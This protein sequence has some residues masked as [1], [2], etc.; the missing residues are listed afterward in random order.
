MAAL[1]EV[2]QLDKLYGGLKAV[3][4]VSFEM[5]E[6]S[7][8]GLIGPNGAGKTTLFNVVSGVEPATSGRVRFR[9]EDVTNW[10]AHRIAK[11]GLSRTF[12]TV[13]LFPQISV[14]DNAMV[15]AFLHT[16]DMETARENAAEKLELVGLYEQRDLPL[17]SLTLVDRKRV[18]MARALC[19]NPELLLLDEVMAGLNPQEVDLALDLIRRVRDSGVTVL[20]VEHILRAI[21]QLC[22][23]ILVMDYGALI[24]DG[25]CEEVRRDPG[26]IAAYIGGEAS[27]V[28]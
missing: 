27:H 1:L 28:A 5:H 25:T 10:P 24:C 2:E 18:E 20:V 26:V 14:I 12:Q 21:M 3:N 15:G 22:D 23:R 11:L 19:T 4:N 7:I 6:G 16:A 17:K 13:R 8:V 9:G